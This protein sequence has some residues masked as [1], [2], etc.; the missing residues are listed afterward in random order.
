MATRIASNDREGTRNRAKHGLRWLVNELQRRRVSR[1]TL[2]Y[3]LILWVNVQ[4]GDVVFPMLSF[5]EWSLKLVV[6]VGLMGLPV[7]IL[8]AWTFQMTPH[9]L[10]MDHDA[11][12]S[13]DGSSE[14]DQTAINVALV[15]VGLVLICCIVVEVA[16][17]AA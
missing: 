8:L 12:A 11:D 17:R 6:A 15:L 3:G 10:R 7:V 13:D 4:I 16:T 1:T 2:S 14:K 5:P 9:G